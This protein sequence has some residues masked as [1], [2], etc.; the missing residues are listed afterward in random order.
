MDFWTDAEVSRDPFRDPWNYKKYE[1]VI[2]NVLEILYTPKKI[3]YKPSTF[4]EVGQNIVM[5]GNFNDM[6]ENSQKLV[7]T[8][9]NLKLG[10]L[11]LFLMKTLEHYLQLFDVHLDDP[12]QVIQLIR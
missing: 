11:G 7:M 8:I 2:D 10:D 9:Q 4:Q 12:V 1:T 6:F 5:M 3:S